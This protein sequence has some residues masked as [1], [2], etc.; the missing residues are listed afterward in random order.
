MQS[1]NV[2]YAVKTANGGEVARSYNL[3]RSLK[4]VHSFSTRIS[5]MIFQ[6]SIGMR[7]MQMLIGIRDS[8]N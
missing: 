6:V 1:V 4:D 7:L 5:H 3:Q 2:N 8:V